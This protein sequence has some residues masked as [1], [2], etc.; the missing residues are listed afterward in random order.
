MLH[1]ACG[2]VGF[3]LAWPQASELFTG[4]P[5][6]NP[7]QNPALT[8]GIEGRHLFASIAG[9]RIGTTTTPRPSLTVDVTLAAHA[10]A[11]KMSYQLGGPATGSIW[12]CAQGTRWSVDQMAYRP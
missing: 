11:I 10:M 6:T 9:S 5:E 8:E 2:R 4:Y 1:P 3:T 7:E 12:V